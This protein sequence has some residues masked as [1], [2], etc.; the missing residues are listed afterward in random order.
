MELY[1]PGLTAHDFMHDTL[2]HRHEQP[3]VQVK[4]YNPGLMSYRMT[5]YAPV[6]D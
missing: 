3:V 5:A 6:Y 2:S 4:L 1:H